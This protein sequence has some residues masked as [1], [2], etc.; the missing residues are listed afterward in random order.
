MNECKKPYNLEHCRR[1]LCTQPKW[2]TNVKSPNNNR[3]KGKGKVLPVAH[4]KDR[5]ESSESEDDACFLGPLRLCKRDRNEH[6][7]LITTYLKA[8][9]DDLEEEKIYRKKKTLF[10]EEILR[11]RVIALD[12]KDITDPTYREYVK[13]QQQEYL[14]L[15]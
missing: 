12:P 10:M 14:L 11:D 1:I 8:L 6:R 9:V 4:T 7:D 3:K 5:D 2:Q 13:M 15:L